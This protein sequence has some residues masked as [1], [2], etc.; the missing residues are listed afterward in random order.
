[1]IDI[2]IILEA[3]VMLI[4][5]LITRY[6]GPD[7]I[8]K[9]SVEQQQ[10]IQFWVDTAVQFAQQTMKSATGKERKAMVIKWLEERNITYNAD[11]LDAMIESAVYR[12]TNKSTI[13]VTESK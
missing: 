4:C 1:M 5:L 8:S 10:E 11:K 6:L 3:I 9:T 2:T 12:L 7:I 13:T